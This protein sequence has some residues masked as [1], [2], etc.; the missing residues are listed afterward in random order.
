MP[1]IWQGVLAP[2][3]GSPAAVAKSITPPAPFLVAWCSFSGCGRTAPS[4]SS[5]P[6]LVPGCGVVGMEPLSRSA[7]VGR[8]PPVPGYVGLAPSTT[9]SS[10]LS[11]SAA[12]LLFEFPASRL[13]WFAPS[14]AY[15]AHMARTRMFWCSGRRVSVLQPP[16]V[17]LVSPRRSAG[18]AGGS[19]ALSRSVAQHLLFLRLAALLPPI[20]C[21]APLASP[22]GWSGCGVVCIEL[23]SRSA[24]VILLRAAFMPLN[25]RGWSVKTAGC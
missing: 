14:R 5:P 4:G 11:S 18:P 3:S 21:F 23:L 17:L 20:W 16:Y 13:A 24:P 12:P 19:S 10:A 7:A 25:W 8:I 2:G 9:G 6:T 1:P 22:L 15:V